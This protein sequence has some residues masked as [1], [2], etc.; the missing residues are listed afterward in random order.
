MNCSFWVLLVGFIWLLNELGILSWGH[1]WPL[2]LIAVGVMMFFKRS[3]YSDYPG[4]YPVPPVGP[5]T[6]APVTSTAIVP[7]D[8]RSEQGH[9]AREGR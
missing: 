4:G 2:Y 9:D 5:P 3:M 7:A 1:S 6:T 8:T